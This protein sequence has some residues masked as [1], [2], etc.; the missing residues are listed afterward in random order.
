MGVPK[1]TFYHYAR[2]VADSN[3]AQKHGNSSSIK[4]RAHTMQAMATLRCILDKS[5]D[6]RPHRSRT[7]AFGE[8][9][10]L[11]VLPTT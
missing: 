11:K 9:V 3:A 7:L 8:K 6:Y 5:A 1:T 2:Y 4:P 10:L